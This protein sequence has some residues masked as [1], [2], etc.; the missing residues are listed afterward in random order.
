MAAMMTMM[1]GLRIVVWGCFSP[2]QRLDERTFNFVYNLTSPQKQLSSAAVATTKQH[3]GVAGDQLAQPVMLSTKF[4][5]LKILVIAIIA[6][7]IVPIY[8]HEYLS[9]P[10]T[11]RMPKLRE[12][13]VVRRV[14]NIRLVL[15]VGLPKT[16]TSAIQCRISDMERHDM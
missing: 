6:V 5:L 7:A 8:F 4:N 1:A 15:H 14:G 9:P 2:A 12:P 3:S 16:A 13:V 10:I 11:V